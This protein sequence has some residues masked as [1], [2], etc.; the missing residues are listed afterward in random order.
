MTLG[1][2]SLKAIRAAHLVGLAVSAVALVLLFA[3]FEVD[4]RDALG[5]ARLL[6]DP[7]SLA[8]F[9]TYAR[10]KITEGF[11]NPDF[12]PR[13]DGIAPYVGIQLVYFVDHKLGVCCVSPVPP[14]DWAVTHALDYERPPIARPLE[15][16]PA[17]ATLKTP[18]RYWRPDWSSASVL[19]D[20]RSAGA[21]K[22]RSTPCTE[23]CGPAEIRA[24]RFFDVR[25][26]P[27]EGDTWSKIPTYTFLAFF[28]RGLEQ[29]KA[30][31][32]A[33]E[34][35]RDLQ[36]MPVDKLSDKTSLAELD[37]AGR[38]VV[39]GQ[40][41]LSHVAS[42]GQ[43]EAGDPGSIQDWLR[44]DSASRA[45][46]EMPRLQEHWSRLEKKTLSEAIAYMEAE[47][48]RL[49][50]VNLLGVTVPGTLCLVAIP[51]AFALSHL[52]LWLHLRSSVRLITAPPSEHFP[53][54]GLYT[55]PLARHA[56]AVSL[57]VLPVLLMA[58]LILRCH[59]RLG[60]SS[61]APACALS[62][63]AALFGW[64]A[65]I[66]AG[67]LRN[68]WWRSAPLED[69]SASG[70]ASEAGAAEQGVAADEARLPS[71]P[72]PRS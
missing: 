53:W 47:Q 52:Q 39:V 62:I 30:G 18:I 45:I 66:E 29:P 2:E 1:D 32:P 55:E 35:W 23:D 9:E 10:A 38:S 7:K 36:N 5:E 21:Q 40:V 20:T 8:P 24:L 57:T 72:A 54:I 37:R 22:G 59:S 33:A 11:E 44:Y 27:N 15:M 60:F 48:R 26:A 16:W 43:R 56:T 69:S 68:E 46:F 25:P 63:G 14:N 6:K 3:P 4:F 28:Q 67:R 65:M 49:R 31:A 42:V 51:L 61:T 13:E 12:L 17:W 41:T 50:D 70:H 71:P 34:W 64:L 58:S 19:L